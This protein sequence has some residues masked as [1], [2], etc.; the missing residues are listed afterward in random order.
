M[1]FCYQLPYFCVSFTSL[2]FSVSKQC[3]LFVVNFISFFLLH[4]QSEKNSD[5]PEADGGKV[6]EADRPPKQ[7]YG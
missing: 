2:R 1:N 7:I 3:V 5:A 6:R 4:E